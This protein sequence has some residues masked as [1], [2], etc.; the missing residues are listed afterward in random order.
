MR[1]HA[2]SAAISETVA[3]GSP[4]GRSWE[5]EQSYSGQAGLT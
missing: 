2:D 5:M 1:K 3:D 4:A